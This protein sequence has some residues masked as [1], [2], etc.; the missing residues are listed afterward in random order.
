MVIWKVE[1]AHTWEK[2]NDYS[3]YTFGSYK[4]AIRWIVNNGKNLKWA[5]VMENNYLP[6]EKSDPDGQLF[7]GC[8]TCQFFDENELKVLMKVYEKIC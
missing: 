7:I 5:S 3:T 6:C 2:E 4:G 8:D 1:C